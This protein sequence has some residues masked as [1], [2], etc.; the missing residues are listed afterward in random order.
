MGSRTLL[1]LRHAKSDWTPTDPNDHDRPLAKRGRL[2][3]RELADRVPASERPEL[4]L[5]SSARRAIETLAGISPLLNGTARVS[6]EHS[7]YLADEDALLSRLHQL[8]PEASSAMLIGHNPAL[9]D[10]VIRVIGQGD[11]EV[12]ES[13]ARHLSTAGLVTLSQPGD[14]ADLGTGSAQLVRYVVP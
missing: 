8:P 6:I 2:T 1:I 4:I 14:W 13:L 9:H 10:L 3:A 7:L 12:V 5:C 11:P